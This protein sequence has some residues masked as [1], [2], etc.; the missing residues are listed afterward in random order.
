MSS[1]L[2]DESAI[3]EASVFDIDEV[4]GEQKAAEKEE[5]WAVVDD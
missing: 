5:I 4:L 3:S 1:K 2:D